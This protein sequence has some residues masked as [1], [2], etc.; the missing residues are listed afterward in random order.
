MALYYLGSCCSINKK[1]V[2]YD[3]GDRYYPAREGLRARQQISV[4][5]LH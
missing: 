2:N 4:E 1:Q 5:P 3:S